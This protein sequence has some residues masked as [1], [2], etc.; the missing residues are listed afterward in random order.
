MIFGNTPLVDHV[1]GQSEYNMGRATFA[2]IYH[3]L[4]SDLLKAIPYL[5]EKVDL[6]ASEVGRATKGAA[7]ALLAKIYL[8]ESS[9]AHYYPGDDRF[10]GLTEKWQEALNACKSIDTTQ[11][12]LVGSK[13]ETY[14]TWHGPNTNG[15]RFMFTLE[16][17]NNDESLFE[18]QYINDKMDYAQTRAG[19]LMQWIAPRYAYKN[20]GRVS[21]SYWGLGWP[22]QSL[23]DEFE[24][25]DVRLNTTI[26]MPGDSI[27]LGLMNGTTPSHET[28]LI[29]FSNS[30]TGYY[31]N[32]W[33]CS[34]EQFA[35]LGPHAWQKSPVNM[36]IMRLSEVYLMAAE[37]AIMLGDNTTA[38]TYINMVR[39]RARACG[40][41]AVPANL[42]GTITMDQLIHERRCELACEGRRFFD[43]V[44]WN[45][46][47]SKL[48]GYTT[49]GGFQVSYESPKFDFCPLPAN[50]LII[51][52]GLKQL[53]GW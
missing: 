6:P 18:V 25:G 48:N 33:V 7:Q 11:Y 53:Y 37:A 13:G 51:N 47:T 5:P 8:F 44:R 26:S 20:G 29:D 28:V 17:D 46:A 16:G 38:A 10:T 1:L 35:D 22:T 24:T 41:G 40:G 30:G 39:S 36:K 19:S 9:Y 3:Y 42:T 45:L 15:F 2:E 23:V 52:S 49:P 31:Q 50:E 14:V 34:G 32:K 43:L 27:Q 12:S 21:T 4:E